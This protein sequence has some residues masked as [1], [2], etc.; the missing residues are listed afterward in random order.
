MADIV[1]IKLGGSLLTNKAIPKEIR[2]DVLH[3]C[4]EEIRT[5]RD[6]NTLQNICII[7]GVGSYGHPPVV[8]HKLHHGL[9]HEDQLLALSK[10]QSEVQEF[11]SRLVHEF[12]MAGLPVILLQASSSMVCDGM[13]EKT[14]FCDPLKRFMKVGMIPVMGGDMVVDEKMG[15]CVCS[16]DLLAVAIAREL[17][18]TKLVFACD[19]EGVYDDDPTKHADAKLIQEYTIGSKALG[20][21]GEEKEDIAPGGEG[22]SIDASGLMA[23]KLKWISSPECVRLIEQGMDVHLISMSHSG[24]LSA[25]L[26]GESVGT[27]FVLPHSTN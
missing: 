22:K 23:G 9:I 17:G 1:V 24:N 4:V 26:H 10:T 16:G 19:V 18:A 21:E 5:L 11:R 8:R 7:H 20:G 25:L 2:E 6:Q 3:S 14:Y 27:H 12:Q 15:F 13:K